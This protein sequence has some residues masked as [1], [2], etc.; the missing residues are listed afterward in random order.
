MATLND[1]SIATRELFER[2]VKHQVFMQTPVL[3]ELQRRSQVTY[4]GGKYIERLVDTNEVNSLAQAYTSNEALSDGK[5]DT[6]EKPRF[7]FKLMQQPMKYDVDEFLQ[8]HNAGTEEQLLDLASFLVEKSQRGI[9]LALRNMMYNVNPSGATG[10]ETGVGDNSKYFQ[11]LISALDH[12]SGTATTYG[13]TSRSFTTNAWW[14]GSDPSGRP[15][16][17][18]TSTQG[19]ATNISI[20]NFRKWLIPIEQYTEKMSDLYVVMCPTLW[21]KLRAELEAKGQHSQLNASKLAYGIQQFEIDGAQIVKDPY[22]ENGYGTS[23]TTEN[24][25]FVLNLNDWELRIHKDRQFKQT[26]FKWQGENS[27]GHDYWLARILLSGNLVCWKPN[28]SMFLS[29][30]S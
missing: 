1:L 17:I 4:S 16:A 7:N 26:E 20:S 15:D 11:S 10:S 3:E 30:V 14:M 9:K 18:T 19:D 8:N 25:C 5:V 13:N 21:N 27:N 6:L 28:G 12:N 29:N 24:W 23:G 2:T 22:L